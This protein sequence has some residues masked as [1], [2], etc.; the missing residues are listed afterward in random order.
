MA[1]TAAG[2]LQVRHQA[3]LPENMRAPEKDTQVECEGRGERQAQ[4]PRV[5][6][7]AQEPEQTQL[8]T[9]GGPHNR[10]GMGVSAGNWPGRQAEAPS[11]G[12]G[13]GMLSPG[14]ALS[15]QVWSV[16]SGSPP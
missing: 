15:A 13:K 2:R 16:P 7:T 12:A 9:M 10:V 11:L 6:G 4:A 5:C 3:A 1:Y 8:E 14:W